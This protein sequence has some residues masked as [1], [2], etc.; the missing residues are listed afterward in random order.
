MTDDGFAEVTEAL[1]KSIQYE[2]ENGRVVKLEEVCLNGNEL[3]ALSLRPLAKVVALAAGNIRDLDLSE[4]RISITTSDDAA[5]WEEFLEAFSSCCALRRIDFSRNGLGSKA[6]EVLAR[7]YGKEK[8]FDTRDAVCT[9]LLQPLSGSRIQAESP[10]NH[11]DSARR[12]SLSSNVKGS[13]EPIPEVAR[14]GHTSAGQ[15]L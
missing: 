12:G 14:R 6:F 8:S 4:N 15:G 9:G 1:V 5:A 13:I 2:D 11:Q 7:V 3:T 10:N